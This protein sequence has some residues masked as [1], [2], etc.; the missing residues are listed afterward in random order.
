MGKILHL[1]TMQE[2]QVRSLVRE[3]RSHMLQK[4]N[5]T[6]LTLGNVIIYMINYMVSLPLCSYPFWLWTL[7]CSLTHR[8][9]RLAVCIWCNPVKQTFLG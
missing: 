1:S 5:K 4:K 3:L 8:Y 2:A 7:T 6:L 9:I